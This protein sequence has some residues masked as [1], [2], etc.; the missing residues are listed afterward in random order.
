MIFDKSNKNNLLIYLIRILL[1]LCFLALAILSNRFAYF[2]VDLQISHA[3][4][5]IHY[6]WFSTVMNLV[7]KLGND[8]YLELIVGLAVGLLLYVGLKAEAIKAALFALISA[9]AGSL[10]KL[11]VARPRPDSSLVQIQEISNGKSFPSLHVLIFTAFFGYMFFLALTKVKT[12]WLKFL[13]ATGSLFL[14]LTVGVSRIY[15]GAHWASDTLGGYLIGAFFISFI[16]D[17]AK[18]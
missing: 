9:V 2:N 15:L 17:H 16:S 4:Q 14:I 6:S 1:V 13:I 8:F 12:P 10:I 3:I 5:N 7:S 18:R 11:V